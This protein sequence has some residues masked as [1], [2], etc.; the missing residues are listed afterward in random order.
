[1]VP[2]DQLSAGWQSP[3]PQASF[4]YRSGVRPRSASAARV[5]PGRGTASFAVANSSPPQPQPQLMPSNRYQSLPTGHYYSPQRTAV[6]AQDAP[7]SADVGQTGT[8]TQGADA[9]AD[10]WRARERERYTCSLGMRD[11]VISAQDQQIVGLRSQLLRLE[12]ARVTASPSPSEEV[13]SSQPAVEATDA[14]G[15]QQD[16]VENR[17]VHSRPGPLL[18]S[19]PR[20]DFYLQL[21]RSRASFVARTCVRPRTTSMIYA[22]GH[23]DEVTAWKRDL[24]VRLRRHPPDSVLTSGTEAALR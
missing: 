1:M 2:R 14:P 10:A 18:A 11:D 5:S 7:R 24:E 19:V 17:W 12:R 20:P 9:D 21:R 4:Q 23:L 6:P 22:K 15:D 3:A 13:A 8:W 16:A